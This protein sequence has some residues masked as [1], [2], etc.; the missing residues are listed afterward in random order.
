MHANFRLAVRLNACA[1]L[2]RRRT[3][4]RKTTW[5]SL[6]VNTSCRSHGSDAAYS[7]AFA[8]ARDQPEQFWAEAAQDVHWFQPWSQ[9]LHV[10]DP[11]FPNWWV[12]ECR[13]FNPRGRCLVFFRL[14]LCNFRY[15]LKQ[16]KK[17][18]VE[19]GSRRSYFGGVEKVEMNQK[20][21]FSAD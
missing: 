5:P 10:Q 15:S 7:R 6:A 4:C 8:A 14:L 16:Y 2:Q 20:L 3:P 19:T 17:V 12:N 9:T 13:S 11:V 21:P 1:T 18:V